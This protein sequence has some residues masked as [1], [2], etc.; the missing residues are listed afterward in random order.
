MKTKLEWVH[1]FYHTLD[2]IP[3]DWYL[4]IE[5]FHGTAEWDILREGISMRFNLEDGFK[6]IDE[7]LCWEWDPPWVVLG[8][9][10]HV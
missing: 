3:M 4:E 8:L 1:I 10:A 7:A 6:C 5:L 2:M 9:K